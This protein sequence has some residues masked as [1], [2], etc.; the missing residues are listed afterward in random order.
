MWRGG[1]NTIHRRGSRL[2]PGSVGNSELVGRLIYEPVVRVELTDSYVPE[3]QDGYL[4]AQKD[5]RLQ[6]SLKAEQ[7]ARYMRG[8]AK[9]VCPRKPASSNLL[10]VGAAELKRQKDACDKRA[11]DRLAL[12]TRE[13]KDRLAWF[14]E[15]DLALI[16]EAGGPEL[17][18]LKEPPV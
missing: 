6:A 4:Q 15:A 17:E 2:A 14:K 18:L 12:W 7:L 13:Q 5:A 1:P 11:A 8:V 9:S 10:V 3:M 16:K